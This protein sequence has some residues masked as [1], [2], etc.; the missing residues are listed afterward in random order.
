[1][2][3]KLL[4]NWPLMQWLKNTIFFFQW[5]VGC[6]G[7]GQF[8]MGTWADTFFFIASTM[9]RILFLQS[10]TMGRTFCSITLKPRRRFTEKCSCSYFVTEIAV[11]EMQL[12]I[13][14]S[15]WNLNILFSHTVH[16]HYSKNYV[17]ILHM[18][19]KTKQKKKNNNNKKEMNYHNIFFAL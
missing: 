8:L 13:Q 1:M 7:T 17:M 16:R 11:T 15:T 3:F 10:P 6:L 12:H 14:K 19:K 9:E 4:V 5:L 18:N 2:D